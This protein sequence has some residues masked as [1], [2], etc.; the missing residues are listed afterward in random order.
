MTP[1]FC[2]FSLSG[3]CQGALS[4]NCQAET[5]SYLGLQQEL[6]VFL[7]YLEN[8]CVLGLGNMRKQLISPWRINPANH[9]LP[10]SSTTWRF[11]W[12]WSGALSRRSGFTV[13]SLAQSLHH[14]KSA[15]LALLLVTSSA[16]QRPGLSIY[17]RIDGRM[18]LQR[19]RSAFLT[20]S[21][22]HLPVHFYSNSFYS[23]LSL[24]SFCPTP[25]FMCADISFVHLNLL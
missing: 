22:P 2:L 23:Y 3:I 5:I 11:S 9:P 19:A 1:F 8:Y 14:S 7:N 24:Q 20:F 18:Q 15:V 10:T 17:N 6:R 25:I 21:S 13:L 16:L 12:L 4:G